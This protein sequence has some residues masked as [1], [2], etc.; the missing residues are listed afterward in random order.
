MAPLVRQCWSLRGHTPVLRER[1]RSPG[2]KRKYSETR[3]RQRQLNF[4]IVLIWYR[5]QAHLGRLIT[6]CAPASSTH[7][8]YLP[9]YTH[10]PE[11]NLGRVPVGLPQDQSTG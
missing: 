4:P 10:T 6:K 8:A 2:C 3:S 11:L 1:T 5:F 9:P 7:L